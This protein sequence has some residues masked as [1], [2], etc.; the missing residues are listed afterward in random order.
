M[1]PE[2]Q[3]KRT[4]TATD[5]TDSHTDSPH[6][7]NGQ[8]VTPTSQAKLASQPAMVGERQREGSDIPARTRLLCCLDLAREKKKKKKGRNA[9]HSM[10]PPPSS[11]S[12]SFLV[13]II[14]LPLFFFSSPPLPFL[15]NLF[16]PSHPLLA[17]TAGVSLAISPSLSL[18]LSRSPPLSHSISP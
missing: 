15:F 5:D 10:D 11:S 6:Q 8:R 18:S 7:Q 4:Q 16:S 14:T 1:T 9:V 17:P 13:S 3:R 2:G 12:S